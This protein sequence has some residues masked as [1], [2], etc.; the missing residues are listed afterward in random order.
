MLPPLNDEIRDDAEC[1]RRRE[2]GLEEDD[3]CCCFG[4]VEGVDGVFNA[5]LA[6]ALFVEESLPRLCIVLGE[7]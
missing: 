3:R 4:G 7:H 2:A 5:P 1:R 6:D